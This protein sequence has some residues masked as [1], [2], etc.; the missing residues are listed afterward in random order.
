M[1]IEQWKCLHSPYIGPFRFG[2]Q[3]HTNV[4]GF[5]LDY[6]T[7]REGGGVSLL[8]T[9]PPASPL[10]GPVTSGTSAG[11]SVSFPPAHTVD[12]ATTHRDSQQTVSNTVR[13]GGR[14][15][16]PGGP[17]PPMAVRP[18]VRPGPNGLMP[19]QVP[20]MPSFYQGM[21]VPPYVS[22]VL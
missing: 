7:W 6:S 17:V 16:V 12:A 5:I 8:Q 19:F 15:P 13:D 3:L 20:M 18:D 14:V 9:S 11:L 4:T 1:Y 10:V 22:N 2:C 21:M